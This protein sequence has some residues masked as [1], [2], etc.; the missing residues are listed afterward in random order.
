MKLEGERQA[1]AAFVRKF[2]SIGLGI[3]LPSLPDP[4]S[5]PPTRLNPPLPTPGGAA[6]VFAE[7]Q[8]NRVSSLDASMGPLTEVDSPMKVPRVSVQPIQL[9]SEP[10]LLEEHWDAIEDLSFDDAPRPSAVGVSKAKVPSPLS[11]T[12]ELAEDKENVLL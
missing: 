2:D 10:S 12:V 11:Q 3:S 6:A 9:S 4:S 5:L 7:R 1:L 8:R